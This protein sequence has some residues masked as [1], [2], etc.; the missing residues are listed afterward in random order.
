MVLGPGEKG[1]CSM[2]ASPKQRL[3]LPLTFL[4]RHH[5]A[6]APRA[7]IC[8]CNSWVQQHPAPKLAAGLCLH[9][10]PDATRGQG[11]LLGGTDLG[12]ARGEGWAQL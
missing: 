8:P 3:L 1:T 5:A 6:S 10:G 7:G 11:G 2:A 9:C 4:S 12:M